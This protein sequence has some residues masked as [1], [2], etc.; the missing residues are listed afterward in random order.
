MDTQLIFSPNE[1]PLIS[2]VVWV[3]GIRFTIHLNTT[4]IPSREKNVPHKNDMGV[5]TM[6]VK[7]FIS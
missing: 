2:R 3:S 1:I 5:I 7:L 6:F 4:G